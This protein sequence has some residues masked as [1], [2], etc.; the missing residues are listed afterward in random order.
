[1]NLSKKQ[2]QNHGQGVQACGGQGRN[3]WG[4]GKDRE[5]G[6]SKGKLLYIGCINNRALLYGTGDHI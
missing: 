4:W 6:I 3:G 2:K 1:M 5:F